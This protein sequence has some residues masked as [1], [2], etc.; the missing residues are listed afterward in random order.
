MKILNFFQVLV[1]HV[2]QAYD[3]LNKS[4]IRVEQPD[5]NLLNDDDE[6]EPPASPTRQ[7]GRFY[8]FPKFLEFIF[9]ATKLFLFLF[10]SWS[11]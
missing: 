8:V 6:A 2:K 7:E 5:I 4:I 1:K 11:N 10:C 9:E 3:L